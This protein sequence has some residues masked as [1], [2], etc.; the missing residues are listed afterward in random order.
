MAVRHEKEDFN[1]FF[2]HLNNKRKKKKK[3]HFNAQV[4]HYRER[5]SDR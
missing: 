3:N 4:A 2:E 1:F 5:S